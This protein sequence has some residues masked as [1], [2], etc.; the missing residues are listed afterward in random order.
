MKLRQ[1]VTTAAAAVLFTACIPS[2]NPFYTDKDVVLDTGLLGEWRGKAQ[3]EESNVWTFE[4]V[5]DKGY[6][7]TVHEKEGG[8]GQFNAHLFKLKEACFLDIIPTD[9]K[10]AT[11]Q[12]GLV[13]CAMFPGHLLIRVS[14]IEPELKLALFNFDWLEKY[15]QEHP[16]ALAHRRQEKSIVLTATTRDLQAFVLKHLGDG[17]LFEKPAAM[18]RKTNAPAEAQP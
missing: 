14:Q 1:I 16:K 5:D 3:S 13:N 12:A 8:E 4:K 7:L 2:L 15:L 6:K 18:V 11:N 10:Y 17:E 9:C